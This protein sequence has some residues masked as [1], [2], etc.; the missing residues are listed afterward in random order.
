LH[1]LHVLA[2]LVT[3]TACA[4]TPAGPRPTSTSK[5]VVAPAPSAAVPPSPRADGRVR[6][7]VVDEQ[8][9]AFGPAPSFG[10]EGCHR[11]G[12]LEIG[13][14]LFLVDQQNALN[15]TLAESDGLSEELLA[16]AKSAIERLDPA[17]LRQPRVGL[18][19]RFY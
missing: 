3:L 12:S 17:A 10:I 5:A 8:G 16:C 1:P 7:D 13:W 11:A 15:V 4:G 9:A 19:L 2:V 6:V 14:A 18:Y